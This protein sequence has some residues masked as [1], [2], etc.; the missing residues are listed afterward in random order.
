MILKNP[1]NT[2]TYYETRGDSTSETLLLLH[3]I[4]AD[5]AMWQPQIQKYAG[6][7]YHLLI[8]DLFGHGLSSQLSHLN[9]SDWHRQINWLLDSHSVEKCTLI[10]ASMGGVIA[11][12][13]VVDHLPRVNKI[14]IT[15]S[16]GELSTLKE[17]LLG[18]SAIVGF[19]LFKLFGKQL[20]A[21]G[22]RST[23]SAEY[24]QQ[25]RDYF[26]QVSLSVD[27]NQMI[28]A[29]KA[30]N[31]IDG[32]N[33][34]KHITLPALVIVGADLGQWFIDINRKIADSLPNAEFVILEKSMDPS[35]LVNPIEF[36]NQV[37]RFL[38]RES[39]DENHV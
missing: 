20:L 9:L 3:G 24:A 39:L 34:L 29:R 18:L 7:G 17:K 30:I 26:E 12:S 23:Y 35:N 33:K 2:E 8:P 32:L 14:I 6:Q 25:A 31:R 4:G 13:F 11:Q 38:K 15:D 10:G 19:N 21:K 22:T 28:L 5:H 37:L 36:D 16:F 27:L 1:D